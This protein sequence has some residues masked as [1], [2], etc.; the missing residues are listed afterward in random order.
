[1]LA[2]ATALQHRFK[3]MSLKERS[4][5]HTMDG[6]HKGRVWHRWGN[7]V[8]GGSGTFTLTLWHSLLD[9]GETGGGERGR[10]AGRTLPPLSRE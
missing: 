4:R 7:G 3:S 8:T 9:A 6:H 2:A 10:D 5:K 1:M